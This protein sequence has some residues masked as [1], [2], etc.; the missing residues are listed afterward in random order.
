MAQAPED[1]FRRPL[2]AAL[3]ACML[4]GTVAPGTGLVGTLRRMTPGEAALRS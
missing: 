2:L 1:D 3:S 4:E